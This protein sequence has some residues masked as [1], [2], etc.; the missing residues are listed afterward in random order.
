MI[1]RA[2]LAGAG[3]LLLLTVT[4]AD[5]PAPVS[6]HDGTRTVGPCTFGPDGHGV[7]TWDGVVAHVYPHN[8][9]AR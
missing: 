6:Q 7:C 4:S 9:A 5:P 1:G 2:L 8:G 3:V